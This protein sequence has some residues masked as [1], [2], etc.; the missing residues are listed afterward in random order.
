MRAVLLSLLLLMGCSEAPSFDEQFKKR[1]TE[2]E[3]E[4]IKLERDLKT[5]IE[6][7]PEVTESMR[8]EETSKIEPDSNR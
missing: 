8:P 5:Q 1:S 6:L 3:R 4:A 7:V 2:I